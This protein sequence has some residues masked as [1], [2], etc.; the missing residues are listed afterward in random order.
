MREGV[1]AGHRLATTLVLR[2]VRCEPRL[3]TGA[4][5]AARMLADRLGDPPQCDTVDGL[6]DFQR[7]AVDRARSILARRG[8]VLIADSV[9]LGKTHVALELLRSA[10][11]SHASV[12]VVGPA[13]LERHWRSTAQGRGE[14]EWLSFERLSRGSVRPGRRDFVVFD[15]AHALRNPGARRYRHAQTLAR[16]AFVVLLTATPVNNSL[17]DLYHLLRIFAGD[18][19][20]M[21]VGVAS[22]RVAFDEASAAC[23]LGSA[24][25]LQPVLREVLIRRT[26]SALPV[27]SAP[28]TA[29]F[30]TQ[31]PPVPVH[32]A[33][34]GV[35]EPDLLGVVGTALLDLAFPVHRMNGVAPAELL[36]R[37]LFKRL[38]SS[39]SAL[40]DSLTRYDAL[41]HRCARALDRGLLVSA[42]LRPDRDLDQLTFDELLY[43]P[44]DDH[45]GADELRVSLERERAIVTRSRDALDAVTDAKLAALERLLGSLGGE[46]V[47]V[48]TQYRDTARYLHARL[49][50]RFRAA[51][52]DGGG[53]LLG[54]V[55][56]DRACVVRRFAPLANGAA[57]PIVCEQVDVLVATDVLSE[58]F[59]LQDASVV[60][61]YDLPWN[62]I[63]LVQRVGRIDRLGSGHER[64]SS[65]HFLPGDLD[66]YLGLVDR[67][68][69]KT[70]AIEATVGSDMPALHVA[71]ARALDRRDASYFERIEEAA[72]PFALD[73]KLR[74]LQR[75]LP[76]PPTDAGFQ[77]ATLPANACAACTAMVA[78]RVGGNVEWVAIVGG[79]ALRDD[80]QCAELLSLAAGQQSPG[81]PL[82]A[83]ALDDVLDAARLEISR[84]QAIV[85]TAPLLPPRGLAQRI[86]RRLLELAGTVPGGADAALCAR[87]EA[88]LQRLA[89]APDAALDP[90]VATG[91]VGAPELRGLLAMVDALPRG[92]RPPDARERQVELLGAIVRSVPSVDA[93]PHPR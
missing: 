28:S 69:A 30:P 39:G 47:I 74:A 66:R 89:H 36:R 78:A 50:Q 62:P 72:D 81:T 34:S 76:A 90:A 46:R 31:A 38:E 24:P 79:R 91:A 12:T 55:P 15:E 26:R 70:S 59:N 63:R 5:A 23:L 48:F 83:T 57:P 35:G 73:A 92:P 60:V 2:E 1:D 40:R 86:G 10:F 9:G 54:D 29:R 58:G 11:Q 80:H 25:S 88:A 85:E 13:A 33:F 75:G 51:L 18:R 20:F 67:I 27:R 3:V 37:S 17:W 4:I 45:R 16:D 42:N 8:G 84:R 93:P 65:Y 21:D 44:I 82:S 7:D 56:V 43:E 22:L 53:A 64:I 68:A 71:V 32:Y 52:I 49:S 14:F 61:S 19:D 6:F 77:Y 41:L 87:I